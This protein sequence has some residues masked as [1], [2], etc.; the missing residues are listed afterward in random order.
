MC[1]SRN[2]PVRTGEN[3]RDGGA[4]R[5]PSFPGL[6]GPPATFGLLL[7][8]NPERGVDSPDSV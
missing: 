8:S 5:E 7:A 3:A 1:P 2:L 6:E 4:K